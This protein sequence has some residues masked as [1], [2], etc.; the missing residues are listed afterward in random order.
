MRTNE[1]TVWLLTIAV[2]EYVKSILSSMIAAKE[3]V[4]SISP[5]VPPETIASFSENGL[6]RR[7][8]GFLAFTLPPNE[9]K[10]VSVVDMACLMTGHP[11]RKSDDFDGRISR[12]ASERCIH[13]FVDCNTFSQGRG[14]EEVRRYIS[15]EILSVAASKRRRVEQAT[16]S[17]QATIDPVVI[18][19]KLSDRLNERHMKG[20]KEA[21]IRSPVVG[22]GRGAKDL[23]ALKARAAAAAKSSGA[24]DQPAE[25]INDRDGSDPQ[26]AAST[27]VRGN[28]SMP[29]SEKDGEA[30]AEAEVRDNFPITSKVQDTPSVAGS[31]DTLEKHPTHVVPNN[32][33]TSSTDDKIQTDGNGAV[34]ENLEE[35]PTKPVEPPESQKERRGKGFGIK[36]LAAMRARSLTKE[37]SYDTT[38]VENWTTDASSQ[39]PDDSPKPETFDS[40]FATGVS[41]SMMTPIKTSDGDDQRMSLEPNNEEEN[42]TEITQVN[43]PPGISKGE[44]D[45]SEGPTPNEAS[46]IEPL[47]ETIEPPSQLKNDGETT[48][49]A[50][51]SIYLPDD[52]E[53]KIDDGS[54]GMGDESKNDDA[55]QSIV[56][57]SIVGE[58]EATYEF[59]ESNQNATK[60]LLPAAPAEVAGSVEGSG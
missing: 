57:Q 49:T 38:F 35:S 7:T 47:P 43:L 13:S 48:V 31:L 36:N 52:P 58:I 33:A 37:G 24:E 3:S 55:K 18:N 4:D 54:S 15:S 28:R 46:S 17:N 12:T 50:D 2:Q 14:F 9:R 39:T 21:R 23:A 10:R 34:N 20:G 45:V 27:P 16:V 32:F 41:A 30:A 1:T 51:L 25:G 26:S 60:M 44:E 59:Q 5:P 6:R 8:A 19:P 56:G 53:E 40:Q 29:A 11:S 42:F 22:L